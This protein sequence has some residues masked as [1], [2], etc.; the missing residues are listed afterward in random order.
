MNKNNTPEI[1]SATKCKFFLKG[2]R[3]IP[4]LIIVLF[5]RCDERGKVDEVP[6]LLFCVD[7]T[8]DPDDPGAS[9]ALENHEGL[10]LVKEE[11]MADPLQ[12]R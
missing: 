8:S 2:G 1:E 6:S 7:E 11:Q 10:V 12:T 5:S 3:N 4:L 9:S